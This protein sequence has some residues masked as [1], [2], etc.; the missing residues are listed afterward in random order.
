MLYLNPFGYETTAIAYDIFDGKIDWR[1]CTPTEQLASDVLWCLK[2]GIYANS[3]YLT[4]DKDTIQ[5]AVEYVNKLCR[6]RGFYLDYNLI[7]TE[8]GAYGDMSIEENN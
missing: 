3:I 6:K 2:R 7:Y 8:T 1:D 4:G 5:H